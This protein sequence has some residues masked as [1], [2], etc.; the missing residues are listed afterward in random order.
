MKKNNS[1]KKIGGMV[2]LNIVRSKNKHSKKKVFLSYVKNKKKKEDCN[3]PPDNGK[4][5]H[6]FINVKENR[7][8]CNKSSKCSKKC[9][10]GCDDNNKCKEIPLTGYE[11]KSTDK[12]W[13]NKWCVKGSNCY[14]YGINKKD[15]YICKKCFKKCKKTGKAKCPTNPRKCSNDKPQPGESTG[16]GINN[17]YNCQD[18]MKRTLWDNPGL[19]EAVE[20]EKCLKYHYKAALAVDDKVG[21]HY[22]RQNPDGSYSHKQGSLPPVNVDADGKKIYSVEKANRIYPSLKY[23]SFCGYLCVPP[24]SIIQHRAEGDTKM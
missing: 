7:L 18:M 6:C 1:K 16:F 24:N 8:E 21:Y 23:S 10:Y 19:Y 14:Y 9:I 4:K 3:C 17:D 5:V 2:K 13:S 12:H 22:W 11:P 20:D 15:K